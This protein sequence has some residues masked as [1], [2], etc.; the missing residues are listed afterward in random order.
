MQDVTQYDV[1]VTSYE[2]LKGD[3]ESAFVRMVWRSIVLDEGHRI[4][5]M[6]TNLSR[7]CIKLR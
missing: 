4:K 5:N 6:L 3:M 1:V 7:V 2:M